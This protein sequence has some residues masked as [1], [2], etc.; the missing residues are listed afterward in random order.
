M[1]GAKYFEHLQLSPR[2]VA[3][4]DETG[5]AKKLSINEMFRE[6]SAGA[7]VVCGDVFISAADEEGEEIDVTEADVKDLKTTLAKDAK[8]R[9][10]FAREMAASGA[11]VM[12]A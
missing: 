8:R 6:L 11:S 1:I 7:W 2:L 4:F 9:A 3:Y 10:E 12:F 5:K